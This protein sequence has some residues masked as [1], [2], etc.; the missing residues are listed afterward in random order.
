MLDR[1]ENNIDKVLIEIIKD[2][3]SVFA[4]KSVD[5]VIKKTEFKIKAF[6]KDY[7]EIELWKVGAGATF[8]EILNSNREMNFYVPDCSV[9]FTANLKIVLDDQKIKLIPPLEVS[10]YE[11]RKHER[12]EF[13]KS[14]ALLELNKVQY[15]KSI[16]DISLGGFALLLPKMERF[17]IKKG[18]EI[19]NCFIEINSRK[20]KLKLEC[21]STATIDRFR[22]EHLPYG[23]YKIAFRFT[24]ISKEDKAFLADLI[25]MKI[26]QKKE[27]KAHAKVV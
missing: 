11:R 24:D 10:Y 18:A 5:G 3:S 4:W 8:S 22:H 16:F 23:G 15:K 14:F 25:T 7:N 21:V 13:E 26:I 17:P 6:R 1:K 19:S 12:V 9:S 20:I 27:L 2:A